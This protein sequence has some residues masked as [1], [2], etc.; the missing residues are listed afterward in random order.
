MKLFILFLSLL[1]LLAVTP[2]PVLAV[3]HP[4][5]YVNSLDFKPQTAEPKPKWVKILE[6][7]IPIFLLLTIVLFF[8]SLVPSSATIS[9]WGGGSYIGKSDNFILCMIAFG[10][11]ITS[12]LILFVHRIIKLIKNRKRS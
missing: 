8:M 11:A 5:T 7:A 6:W 10:I 2:V 1:T 12:A 4:H 9:V 3:T